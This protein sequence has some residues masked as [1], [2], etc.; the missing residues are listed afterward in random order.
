MRKESGE[1]V[2]A[3][4]E[5]LPECPNFLVVDHKEF[6]RHG[7]INLYFDVMNYNNAF[8][9]GKPNNYF[10]IDFFITKTENVFSKYSSMFTF[11]LL[12]HPGITNSS[13]VTSVEQ[14]L[15]DNLP[16]PCGGRS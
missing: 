6:E 7:M 14:C 2:G 3:L 16:A 1:K 10:K 13:V 9:I 4:G 8:L 12:G 11:D 5:E 15:V